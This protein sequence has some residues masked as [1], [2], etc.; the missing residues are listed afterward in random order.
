MWVDPKTVFNPNPNPN[1]SQVVSNRPQV[2]QA[3]T[4]PKL[5]SKVKVQVQAD[6]WV[7]IKFRFSN[8][9]LSW[10]SFKEARHSNGSQTELKG[11]Q[12]K[13]SL[14]M[15]NWAIYTNVKQAY[16]SRWW[17]NFYFP[18]SNFQFDFSIFNPQSSISICSSKFQI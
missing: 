8:R 14:T 16:F 17:I 13:I 5:K 11:F 3:Q 2:G 12:S 7:F 9:P 4:N 10:E 15:L 18:N 1:K 6:N